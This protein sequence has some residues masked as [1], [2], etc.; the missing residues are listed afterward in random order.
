MRE[1]AEAT[2]EA[3]L[4]PDA[5]SPPALA[6]FDPTFHE[7]V[8]GILASRLK[9]RFHRPAFVF[10]RGRDGSLKGSGRSIAGFH[11]RDA[12]DL[13][14]KRAPG[15]LLRFGGH[16][17]AAGCTIASERFEEFER[18]LQ[19][20][21]AEQLDASLLARRLET[22][23]PL[24]AEHF[25][26]DTVR[27][28]DAQVWGQAF[29]APVWADD[30]D[31]LSQRLVGERHLKLSLRHGGVVHEAIWFGRSEP[32]PPRARIAYRLSLD[33]YNGRDRVQMVVQAA[34]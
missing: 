6:L 17:M 4:R 25:A 30:V 31:V 23:G 14:S 26:I 10:A 19:R 15:L 5:T 28:L 16:A 12:L 32:L 33:H 21:A 24:G 8:V 2:L 9:D 13:V 1:Q 34:A 22:D 29:D 27:V 7:G 20:V 18:E 11:L 3:M